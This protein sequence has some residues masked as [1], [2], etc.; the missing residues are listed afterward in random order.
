VGNTDEAP[1]SA[2]MPEAIGTIK[3]AGAAILLIQVFQLHE[4]FPV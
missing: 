3:F 1:R 2:A 4:D